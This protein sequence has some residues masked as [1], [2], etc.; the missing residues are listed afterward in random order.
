MKTVSVPASLVGSA[1]L[2][3]IA[4][5]AAG[6]PPPGEAPA[7]TP[8]VTQDEIV[9]G[10]P[11]DDIRRAGRRV[12]S[13]PFNKLDG[14]GDGPI[15]PLDKTSPGG[16]PSL[17]NN[18]TFLRINGLDGQTCLECHSILSNATIPATFGVGG[19]GGAVSNAMFQPRH[20]DVDDEAGEGFATYDGRFINPPFLF[21]SGGVELL[22]K[23]MTA[24]LLELKQFAKDHPGTIVEL[25]THKV[26]FGTLR[27]VD[28]E[29]DTSGVEGIDEDLIVRP[30][31]RK[32]EFPTVRAFDVDA[33]RFHFGIEPV[34]GVGK[35]NDN[36]G[37]GVVDELLVGEISALHIFNTTLSPPF[38]E[39]PTTE[40][41][42][43]LR[44]FREIGCAE[45]HVPL[46]KTRTKRLP[47][48]FPEDPARPFDN[49]FLSVDLSADPVGFRVRNN[50]GGLIIP[51]F[52]DLKRHDMGEILGESFGTE[53]DREFTTARLWGVADTAPYLHDGRATTLTEAIL[54]HGGEALDAR[55]AFEALGAEERSEILALLRILRVPDDPAAK[56]D[57]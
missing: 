9:G 29:F 27:F 25:R 23:E 57:E 26:D 16:R 7:L 10:M 21:G 54:L 34:E 52:A 3:G 42:N 5:A 13:T 35:G 31:G 55:E 20:I 30:F 12:F 19:V 6:D 17:Q 28:G 40:A 2:L 47:Y 43:G 33:M 22:A 32:G 41:R 39:E 18:G 15:D 49:E 51:M 4:L 1:L 11:L 14:Y 37:D 8:R 36:D 45:C 50:G 44:H 24:D 56:L 53:L 48:N 46:M 38:F